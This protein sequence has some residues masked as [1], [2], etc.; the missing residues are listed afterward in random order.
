VLAGFGYAL[1]G[2]TCECD[3]P[4]EVRPKP[5]VSGTALSHGDRVTAPQ[6]GDA[7]TAR[8]A[9]GEPLYN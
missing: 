9:R 1:E 8:V 6:I 5:I 4:P 2:I 3:Y 7:V